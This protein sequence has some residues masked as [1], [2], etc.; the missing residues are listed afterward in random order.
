[1]ILRALLAALVLLGATPAG[2]QIQETTAD[3]PVT[4]DSTS[5]VAVA[6]L[7][8][9]GSGTRDVALS[10]HVT[11]AGTGLADDGYAVAIFRDSAGGT[12]VGRAAWLP[13]DKTP[14]AGATQADTLFVTGFDPG[15]TLPRTYVLS[16]Y[17]GSDA[18]PDLIAVTRGFDAES[19]LPGTSLA[20]VER[21]GAVMPASFGTKSWEALDNL[22]ID[23]GTSSDVIVTAHF[24]AASFGLGGGF[25]YEIGICRNAAGGLLL[26]QTLWRPGLGTSGPSTEVGDTIA[27]TAFD[28]GASGPVDYVLCARALD[29][30]APGIIVAQR[31]LHAILAHPGTREFADEDIDPPGPTVV[32]STSLSPLGSV[33]VDASGPY[34]VRLTA[35]LYAEASGFTDSV[36]QFAICRGTASGPIVG[37]A[38]WEPNRQAT[39]T[40]LIGDTI[41]F[42]GFDRL[43]VGPTTYVL[44]ARKRGATDVNASV[45]MH[46]LVATVPE[47]GSGGLGVA[48]VAAVA[49]LRRRPRRGRRRSD[50]PRAARRFRRG[51]PMLAATPLL[52]PLALGFGPCGRVPGTG[53]T[54]PVAPT[55]A[56]W[57]A[58]AKVPTCALETRPAHPHSVTVTCFTYD[59][60]VYV[61]SSHGGRKRWTAYVLADPRVRLQVGHEVYEMQATR[62]DDP[63]A[64]DALQRAWM[65][66][67]AKTAPPGPVSAPPDRW[68]FRLE[69]RN[70]TPE[71]QAP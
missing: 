55:P 49:M 19:A 56:D 31:G 22:S 2:A 58:V 63:G 13:S 40:N 52:L 28:P 57:S 34:S 30:N 68:F 38:Y 35:H 70:A 26:G 16:V 61:P 62:V 48:A 71:P 47:P 12:A 8:V 25:R 65:L 27:I 37:S 4:I 29:D 60:T 15:V 9:R 64:R 41:A 18:D 23:A 32:S 44:C 14:A 54:A 24:I 39:D 36:Y 3:H 1:M 51:R 53:L 6:S 17:K 42:T 43:R 67:Y 7:T 46:G 11:L 20:G 10:A 21:A 59:G 66:K 69:P 5:P 45:F 50:G 33:A